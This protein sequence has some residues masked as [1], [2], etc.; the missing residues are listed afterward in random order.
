MKRNKATVVIVLCAINLIIAE[1][2]KIKITFQ[3]ILIIHVFL[4][5]LA[6]LSN[7]IQKKVLQLQNTTAF[8]LLSINFLRIF[9]CLIFL[10]PIILKHEESNKS[11][12]YNFFA[13]Y[14]FYLLYDI[15]F[16]TKQ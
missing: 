4:F 10:L 15:I 2:L 7:K 5:S 1:K 11:Y 16:K 14:F 9:A 13:C 3:Q 8:R 6:V 12:I